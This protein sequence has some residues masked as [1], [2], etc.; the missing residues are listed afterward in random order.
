MNQ[1]ISQIIGKDVEL[2]RPQYGSV[3]QLVTNTVHSP[4]ILWSI[5]TL[6]WMTQK[7]QK[8]VDTIL[9]QARD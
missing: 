7:I 1:I 5:D 4:L 3:N 6:D 9:D 8:T 2:L